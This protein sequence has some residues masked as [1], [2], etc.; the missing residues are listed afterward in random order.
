MQRCHHHDADEITDPEL[1]D[2]LAE[3]A[4]RQ[5]SGEIK[6][7]NKADSEQPGANSDGTHQ[8]RCVTQTRKLRIEAQGTAESPGEQRVNGG[9]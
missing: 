5:E 3:R 9:R 1:R 6:Y 4:G 7:A 2:A 8:N